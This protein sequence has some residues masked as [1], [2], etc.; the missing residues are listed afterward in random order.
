MGNLDLAASVLSTGKAPMVLQAW[1][2]VPVGRQPGLPSVRL[3]GEVPVDPAGGDFFRTVIEQRKRADPATEEGKRL[4]RFLKV[5]A[6]SGAYGIFVE[7][8]PQE[9]PPG[10]TVPV[11][12]YGPDDSPFGARAARP[13]APGAF[14]F[15]PAAALI[16]A[17]AKLILAQVERLVAGLGG[18]HV[19]CDTDSMAIVASEDGGLLPCPGGPHRTEDGRE[20]VRALSWA[21]V[22]GVVGRLAALNPYDPAAVPGSVLK[23]EK[24]N[25]D[26]VT[27]QRRQLW[28]IGIAAKRYA[29]VVREDGGIPIV[30]DHTR[31]GLGYLLDPS[32]PDDD[33]EPRG[34]Q[35]R[36][37]RALWAG[38]VRERLGLD[39]DPLPWAERPAVTRL[40]V[41]SPWHLAA[42]AAANRGKP[43]AD[44]GKP[45][46]FML[47]APLAHQGRPTGVGSGD[48][49]RLV[50]PFETDPRRW[51]WTTWTDLYSG[52]AYRVTAD[53]PGG[54]DGVGGVQSLAAVAEAYPFHP[55]PK[56]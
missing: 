36:W 28:C 54:G 46:N 6:N 30:V 7:A 25:F 49:F 29:L 39:A 3:R 9:L 37:E 47:S 48:P 13:E 52:R 34:E 10:E 53:W 31:H 16:T 15:P 4:G 50:A 40:T 42:F 56:R 19:F 35:A 5:L 44:Q 14:C 24:V 32:D 20:A 27:G 41:S 18:T 43:Y 55:E 51:A 17:G 8:N 11:A 26:P 23:V 45:F 38:I 1:R 22:E 2:P 12:V 33:E 21:E